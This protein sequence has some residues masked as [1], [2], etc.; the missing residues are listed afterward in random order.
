MKS[1]D[2]TFSA[3]T[4]CVRIYLWKYGI[5]DCVHQSQHETPLANH[6]ISVM[7]HVWFKRKYGKNVEWNQEKSKSGQF[8]FY[9]L[10]CVLKCIYMTLCV[11]NCSTSDD[12][13]SPSSWPC[14]MSLTAM[15]PSERKGR[16]GDLAEISAFLFQTGESFMLS[17]NRGKMKSTIYNFYK[18]T[19]KVDV[20]VMTLFCLK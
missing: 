11:S 8:W 14:L 3:H 12:L 18:G 9:D 4:C 7:W 5:W 16:R 20:K 1:S 15:K 17:D 10:K 2:G 19:F 13:Q 6:F